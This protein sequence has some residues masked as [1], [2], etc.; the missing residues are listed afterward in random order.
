[1]VAIDFS[2]ATEKVLEAAA[3]LAGTDD[4]RVVLFSVVEFP[5][6]LWSFQ[7]S[8]INLSAIIAKL[9]RDLAAKLEGLKPSLAG[10]E[11]ETRTATGQVADAIVR[12]AGAV[13][14]DTIVIGS[15]GHAARYEFW[16]GSTTRVVLAGSACPVVVARGLSCGQEMRSIGQDPPGQLG[17]TE[18]RIW[19]RP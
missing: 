2:P 14:A 12:E 16:L 8:G 11:V 15:E 4:Y 1:L 9:E 5:A 18:C 17:L 10:I 19:T 3:E 7:L 13:E 6:T